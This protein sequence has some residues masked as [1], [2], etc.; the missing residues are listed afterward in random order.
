MELD[1]YFPLKLGSTATP[2][3]YLGGK[4]SKFVFPIGVKSYAFSS[5]QYVQEYLN[6]VEDPL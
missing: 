6:K 1:N 3:I 2:N 5:N 4:V